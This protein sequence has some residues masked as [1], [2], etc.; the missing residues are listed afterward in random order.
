MSPVSSRLVQISDL[1]DELNV[2]TDRYNRQVALRQRAIKYYDECPDG[3]PRK[4]D[5][6][7]RMNEIGDKVHHAENQLARIIDRLDD[8]GH[9]W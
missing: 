9:Q 5:A 8:L 6:V 7:K 3:D 1:L 2:W 4:G